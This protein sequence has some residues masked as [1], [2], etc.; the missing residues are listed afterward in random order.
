MEVIDRKFKFK[1]ISNKSGKVYTEKN[2]LVFLIKDALLPDLL[3]KYKELCIHANVDDRQIRGVELLKD[4]VLAWQ[5]KNEKK[6]HYPDIEQG[7]E[8]KRVCKPNK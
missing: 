3:D 5:R 8:E 6:V 4:R 2:A 7:K 1:A